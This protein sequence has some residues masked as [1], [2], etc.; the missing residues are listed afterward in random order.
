[1]ILLLLSTVKVAPDCVQEPMQTN[2]C[3]VS[4]PDIEGMAQSRWRKSIS[5]P[6]QADDNTLFQSIP[7]N[8]NSRVGI[9]G[10]FFFWGGGLNPPVRVYRRSFLCEN[11]FKISIAVQNLKHFN[12]WPPVL[13][14]QFQHWAYT[15]TNPWIVHNR[16]LAVQVNSLVNRIS[17]VSDRL[18]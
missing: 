9:A 14:G 12:M 13:L 17:T 18:A 5:T 3:N 6:E 2:R 8:D 15:S 4:V 7:K 16:E 11:R 10:V 1:M